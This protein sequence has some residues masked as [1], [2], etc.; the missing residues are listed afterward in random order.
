MLRFSY[1]FATFFVCTGL[2][3]AGCPATEA[4][5]D[6]DD[7]AP[8]NIEGTWSGTM[9]CS[10]PSGWMEMDVDL[11]LV[12]QGDDEFSGHFE[13]VG[14]STLG[15]DPYPLR[16]EADIVLEFTAESGAQALTAD[17]SNCET[18]IGDEYSDA[19]C[20]FGGTWD[21]DGADIISMADGD[22]DLALTRQ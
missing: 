20:D 8:L 16:L 15:G 4:D 13:G 17:W 21:W 14:E 7:D 2:L 12:D 10:D 11:P 3:V 9:D 22:C 6:D 5:D 19:P 1:L 18:W